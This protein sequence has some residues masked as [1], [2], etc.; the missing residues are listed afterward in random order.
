[1]ALDVLVGLEELEYF[2]WEDRASGVNVTSPSSST[3]NNW[4]ADVFGALTKSGSRFSGMGMERRSKR[5]RSICFR[6]GIGL[7]RKFEKVDDG[8]WGIVQT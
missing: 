6:W 5:L 4:Q 3:C 7:E 1:M 8:S 2:E